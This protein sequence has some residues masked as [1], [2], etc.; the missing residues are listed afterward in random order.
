MVN[1]YILCGVLFLLLILLI[2][3]I[4]ILV[5]HIEETNKKWN[6]R[7]IT[8]DSHHKSRHNFLILLMLEVKGIKTGVGTTNELYRDFLEEVNNDRE[9]KNVDKQLV[10]D[11]VSSNKE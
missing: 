1:L 6:K 7:Y 10:K 11:A 5:K 2:I 3:V 4:Y 8:L 9:I